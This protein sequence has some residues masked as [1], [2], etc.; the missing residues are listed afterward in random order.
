MLATLITHFLQHLTHQNEWSRAYLT[1]FAG[2]IIRFDFS[3][4]HIQLCILEDGSLS[5]AGETHPPD[6]TV[7][8]PPSLALRL[9]AN[10]ERAK[11]LIKI[12]GHAPLATEVGK[13]LQHMRWDIEDDLSHAVGDIAAYKISQ[14]SQR[15]YA[16]SKHQMNNLAEMF[17]EYW[18][19]EQPLLAKKRHVAQFN[20]DVDSL[21][22]DLD[23]FEKRLAKVEKTVSAFPSSLAQSKQP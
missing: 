11:L 3:L 19:E 8:L 12:D 23:R 9:L 2:Q 1:P 21:R 22:S 14:F 18:Q 5:V 7:H 13:V 17:A 15:A 4:T 20:A 6:A 16:K 10:D